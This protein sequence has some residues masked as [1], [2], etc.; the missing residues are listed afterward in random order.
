MHLAADL[1]PDYMNWIRDKFKCGNRKEFKDDPSAIYFPN[2]LNKKN[3][4]YRFDAGLRFPTPE[5][6]EW[7]S[8]L[9]R[10]AALLVDAIDSVETIRELTDGAFH[11]VVHH[12]L[13]DYSEYKEAYNEGEAI[14]RV[15]QHISIAELASIAK[16]EQAISSI[17]ACVLIYII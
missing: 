3:K 5:G 8:Y 11:E 9:E 17:I 6:T 7:K 13:V 1:R 14:D 15:L 2:P 10:K 4:T 16:V 12:V